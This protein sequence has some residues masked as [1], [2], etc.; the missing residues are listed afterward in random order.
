MESSHLVRRCCES[1]T[2]TRAHVTAENFP[3]N[4]VALFC[5]CRIVRHPKQ[6]PVPTIT[7]YQ[8]F[9]FVERAHWS[10]LITRNIKGK[11]GPNFSSVINVVIYVRYRLE[12]RK[13]SFSAYAVLQ[14]ALVNTSIGIPGRNWGESERKRRVSFWESINRKNTLIIMMILFTVTSLRPAAWPLP[15]SYSFY[16]WFDPLL[17]LPPS[18]YFIISRQ[19]KKV[20]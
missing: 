13:N 10:L 2:A 5:R 12:R 14:K 18:I 17:L 16:S 8:I 15:P 1:V 11:L 3:S 20:L 19:I 4:T 9:C 7:S 6:M